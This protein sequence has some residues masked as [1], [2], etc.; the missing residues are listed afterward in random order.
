MRKTRFMSLLFLMLSA[1]FLFVPS[2]RQA[3]TAIWFESSL[4]SQEPGRAVAIPA[5]QVQ[6]WAREAEAQRDARALAFVAVHL[7]DAKEAARAAEAAVAADP[8][9]GWIYYSM[10]NNLPGRKS[11]ET[12]E[13]ARKLQQFDPENAIGYLTE[14]EH[15]RENSALLQ[16]YP[17]PEP[18]DWEK[19]WQQTE[20]RTAMEKALATPR[21][22]NY[23]LRRFD[24]ERTFLRE[25]GWATPALM[26]Y[27]LASYPIPNLLNIRHYAQMTVEKARQDAEKARRPNDALAH[28]WRVAHFGERMQVAPGVSLIEQLIAMAVQK[29]AYAPLAAALRGGGQ[30]EA[31]ATL[32]YIEAEMK[33]R[34]AELG[35]K[36]ILM[37]SSNHLWN[38]IVLAVCVALVGIFGLATVLSVLF[39]NAKRWFRKEKQGVTYASVTTAENYLPVLLFVFCVG[40]YVSYY[41]YARNFQHVM[42]AAGEMN[43]LEALFTH[44]LALP[45]DLVPAQQLPIGNPFVPYVW[46][47]LGGVVLA[48]VLTL[49]GGRETKP[50]AAEAPTP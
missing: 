33:R 13:W 28:Y 11:A 40:L 44:T 48:V 17:K 50:P 14:A 43:N 3:L 20:W 46:Y 10:I 45:L 7:R 41:P 36:D 5:E 38:A 47:A 24:L 49:L 37:L 42:T 9:L 30:P 21:Y 29:M 25:R 18:P 12:L 6:R 35:G 27:S 16:S 4:D 26:V 19:F 39:V 32:D 15:F 22:D 23:N 1:A 8:K 31:A 2:F 34:R